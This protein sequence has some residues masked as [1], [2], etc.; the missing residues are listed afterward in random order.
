MDSAQRLAGLRTALKMSANVVERL[1]RFQDDWQVG[2]RCSNEEKA[3]FVFDLLNRLLGVLQ[4]ETLE[5]CIKESTIV[6]VRKPVNTLKESLEVFQNTV[7]TV[8]D[9]KQD[10][11]NCDKQESL[12]SET[13]SCTASENSSSS[14][15]VEEKQFP[16]ID[17]IISAF[18]VNF[19]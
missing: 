7:V 8:S 2:C 11:E 18:Q 19:K 5:I 16:D 10:S 6:E 15:N 3:G 17:D 14:N 4:D 1:E 9:K 12:A 13:S